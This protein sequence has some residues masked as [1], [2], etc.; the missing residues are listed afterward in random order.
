MI[1]MCLSISATFKVEG[2]PTIT[3]IAFFPEFLSTT[4]LGAGDAM[5]YIK[6]LS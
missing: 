3:L 6:D 1:S 4:K 5:P 2:A